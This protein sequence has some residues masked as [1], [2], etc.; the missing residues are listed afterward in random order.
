MDEKIIDLG[1]EEQI[2]NY[3]KQDDK[4]YVESYVQHTHTGYHNKKVLLIQNQNQKLNFQ[5]CANLNF[6]QY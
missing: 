6:G 3:E 1:A 4:L 2:A 5:N